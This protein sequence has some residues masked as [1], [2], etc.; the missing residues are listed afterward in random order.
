MSF[1]LLGTGGTGIGRT[2]SLPV[3]TNFTAC[4]WAFWGSNV[5]G[6]K[7]IFILQNTVN[8][9]DAT[10]YVTIEMLAGVITLVTTFVSTSFALTPLLN[11]W[12]F[13]A[14]TCAGTGAADLKGYWCEAGGSTFKTASRAG[15][16]F[17]PAQMNWG[18]DSFN[19]VITARLGAYKVW[20]TVLTPQELLGEMNYF[21]ARRPGAVNG[22]WPCVGG[23]LRDYSGNG[24]TLTMTGTVGN[25]PDP[26][27]WWQ[28]MR[29]LGLPHRID[30]PAAVAGGRIF[31]LAGEGGGLA[32]PA[33]GLA[34]LPVR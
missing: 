26:P 24:R 23:D 4:G 9:T 15:A 22:V 19:N 13:W 34:A 8:P 27:I 31:K 16:S 29:G 3:S 12:F 14:L 33:R 21:M 18:A 2:A 1:V 25:H 11:S 17:T 28:P 32:G 7:P 10:A 30:V 20:D 6:D 5:A